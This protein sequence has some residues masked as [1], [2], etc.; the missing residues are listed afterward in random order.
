MAN[1]VI[2][3]LTDWQN[4]ANTTDSNQPTNA[5]AMSDGAPG[6]LDGEFRRVKSEMRDESIIK[7]WER[8]KGLLNVA[9]TAFIAFTYVNQTQFSVNDNFTAE[10]RLVA[11]A[12]RRVRALLGT[13][14]FIYG[15][16]LSVQFSAGSTLVS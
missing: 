9:G 14:T 16:I 8:W 12:G 4:D 15:T 2:D 13:S 11:Q 1:P 7:S 10:P 6:D 5:T 3:K